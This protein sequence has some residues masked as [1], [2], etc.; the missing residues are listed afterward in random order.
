MKIKEIN[1]KNFRSYKSLSLKINKNTNI[2]VGKNAQGKTN[3]I[4]SIYVLGITKSHRTFLEKNLIKE[5]EDFS[6]I[7]TKIENKELEIIITQKGKSLKINKKP[8]RKTSEYISNLLVIM[9]SPEDLELI[10]GSPS[11][12]RKYLN[13]EISQLEKK[14]LIDIN[15]F[16]KA[17]KMRN[18]YLKQTTESTIDKEYINILNERLIK[19]ATEITQYRKKYIIDINKQLEKVA[20]ELTKD[21]IKIIYKPNP[22]NIENYKDILEKN[23]KRD[24]FQ[25][26]TTYGPHRDDL[27]FQTEGKETNEYGSQ[28]QQRLAVLSLKLS[29]IEIIKE[30]T[31]EYPILLLDDVFSELDQEKRN[32]IIK[33]L[34][35]DIQSFITTTD[36]NNIE[37]SLLLESDIFFVENSQIKGNLT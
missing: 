33:F 8:I 15:E 5:S 6:K 35:K 34:K 22:E 12:R 37:K 25:K 32:N 19:F 23:I 1:I 18:E 21:K 28:G 3:L 10:K 2:F 11:V 20:K 24:L 14:Y 26:A 9:F 27:V 17:L 4:E 36:L 30:K 7:S 31:K 29:E 13:V 16:T